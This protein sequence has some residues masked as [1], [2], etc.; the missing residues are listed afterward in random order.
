MWDGVE[1]RVKDVKEDK[2]KRDRKKSGGEK[3]KEG[4]VKEDFWNEEEVVKD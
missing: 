2:K 1:R 4:K 3:Y